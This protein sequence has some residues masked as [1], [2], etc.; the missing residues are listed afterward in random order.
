MKKLILIFAICFSTFLVKAG[1]EPSDLVIINPFVS[2]GDEA[3]ELDNTICIEF[4][5]VNG[6]KINLTYTYDPTTG[7]ITIAGAKGYIF[8]KIT[9]KKTN[10][11]KTT[12]YF[13][14]SG[15]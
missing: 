14:T 7:K 15:I 5:D 12:K 6:K 3:S 2:P 9:N 10:K 11:S 4:Y 1:G 8:V 13:F